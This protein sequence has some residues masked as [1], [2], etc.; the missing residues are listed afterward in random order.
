MT[1]RASELTVIA[2]ASFSGAIAYAEVF[3][4]A[5]EA[6]L[7]GALDASKIAVIASGSDASLSAFFHAHDGKGRVRLSFAKRAADDPPSWASFSGFKDKAGTSW[8]LLSWQDG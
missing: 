8:D 6:V 2:T 5:V 4:C 3:G 1:D 7:E